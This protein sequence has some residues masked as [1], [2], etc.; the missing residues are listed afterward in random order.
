MVAIAVEKPL[1]LSLRDD[2]VLAQVIARL[3]TGALKPAAMIAHSFPAAQ[4]RAA[5]DLIETHPE[6]TVKVQLVF[7]K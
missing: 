6:Q 3:E 4:S 5:F 7:G 2:P 1:V